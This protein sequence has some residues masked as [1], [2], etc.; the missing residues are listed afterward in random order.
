MGLWWE[1][2]NRLF[3][4]TRNPYDLRRTAGGSSGGESALLSSAASLISLANDVGGSVRIPSTFCG[5]FG[6]KPGIG[7]FH[8][9]K[10]QII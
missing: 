1:T 2:S 4:I 10:K 5:V 3:G 9:Y 8:V 7:F 6:L